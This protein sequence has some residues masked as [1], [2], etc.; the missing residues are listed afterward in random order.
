MKLSN[1]GEVGQIRSSSGTS[2]KRMMKELTLLAGQYYYFH[3]LS[4][5][6][7]HRHNILKTMIR[8]PKVKQLA[9]PSAKHSTMQSTPVLHYTD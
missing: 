8:I 9:R 6:R 4:R 7:A 5:V 1:L 2:T 3:E